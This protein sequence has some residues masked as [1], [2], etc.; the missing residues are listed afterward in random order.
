MYATHHGAY[1][2]LLFEPPRCVGLPI[3]VP[4][5]NDCIQLLLLDVPRTSDGLQ[6]KEQIRCC[7]P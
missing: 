5:S 7:Q 6:R 4:L 2:G 1:V 3:A